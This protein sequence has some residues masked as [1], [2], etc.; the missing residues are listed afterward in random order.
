MPPCRLRP[1]R[2]VRATYTADLRYL[3]DP[4]QHAVIWRSLHP[5]HLHAKNDAAWASHTSTPD[6]HAWLITFVE[7]CHLSQASELLVF[8]LPSTP[9]PLP[10]TS[11]EILDLRTLR[12]PATTMAGL[13]P[14]A[15]PCSL[16][17]RATHILSSHLLQLRPAFSAMSAQWGCRYVVEKSIEPAPTNG[18]GPWNSFFSSISLLFWIT[19]ACRG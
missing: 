16:T 19:L 17:N 3:V 8:F 13:N 18:N 12:S 14:E 9:L 5:L 11:S 6:R 10:L 4:L 7:Q 1:H 2:T 15:R